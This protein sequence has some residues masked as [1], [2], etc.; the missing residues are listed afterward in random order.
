MRLLNKSFISLL[1]ILYIL[2]F[3]INLLLIKKVN[4]NS[5]IK[6]SYFKNNNL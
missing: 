1:N 5:I 6:K 4:L 3:S 2:S